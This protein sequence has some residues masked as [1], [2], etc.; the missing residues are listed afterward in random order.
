MKFQHKSEQEII[1][2][3]LLPKGIYDFNVIEATEKLS[4][5]GNEMIVIKIM[6]WDK[7]GKERN[8]T[9]YLLEAME[10]KLRHFCEVT[11]LIDKYNNDELTDMDCLNKSGKV[12][13]N[14]KKGKEKPDGG[15]YE[16]KNSVEDY[17]KGDNFESDDV[18]F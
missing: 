16:D 5:A 17:V 2:S 13:I 4:K 15:F 3:K 14:I 8:I 9:D 18:P 6:V 10:F 7:K 11:G 12:L 1:E